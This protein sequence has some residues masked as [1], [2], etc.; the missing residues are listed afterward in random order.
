M[1]ET[2]KK[3]RPKCHNC[4]YRGEYFKIVG[5]NHHHCQHPKFD[6]E[7]IKEGRIS[8]WD[9]L[10]E[11]WDTCDDHKFSEPQPIKTK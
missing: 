8:P 7:D 1:E 6:P 3:K 5:Q 10:Q 9:T 4:K 2:T 11:W